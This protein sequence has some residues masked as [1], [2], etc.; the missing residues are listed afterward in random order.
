MPLW[1]DEYPEEW[2]EHESMQN[3]T[4]DTLNSAN[5]P[6]TKWTIYSL[7]PS[8]IRLDAKW[9]Q[10]SRFHKYPI[11][12]EFEGLAENDKNMLTNA[13]IRSVLENEGVVAA[14]FAPRHGIRCQNEEIKIDFL[15]CFECMSGFIYEEKEQRNF[16]LTSD[17]APFF[18]KL[19]E[20][21]GIKS[22]P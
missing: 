19:L 13:L 1:A 18:N 3:S 14:C 12:G 16:L 5:K 22:A 15:I 11:I 6:E 10:T 21:Y 8:K 7:Y 2:K 4:I 17:G 9:E 20:Q